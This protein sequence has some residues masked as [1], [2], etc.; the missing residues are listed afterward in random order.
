M[1][2][3][4]TLAPEA[5]QALSGQADDR[6]FPGHDLTQREQEVLALLVQGLGNDEI[7]S[8]MAISLATTKR[9]VSSCISK[10]GATNRAQAAALAVKHD[11]VQL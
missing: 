4:S 2:D 9:H 1:L 11:L 8:Q 3:F 10:L 6:S 5:R 7:A